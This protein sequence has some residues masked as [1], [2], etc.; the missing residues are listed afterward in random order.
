LI[1][2]SAKVG[3]VTTFYSHDARCRK[4][5]VRAGIRARD[6]PTHSEDLFIDAEMKA[7]SPL[8]AKSPAQPKPR[9]NKQ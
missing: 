7:A 4:L 3:G 5:A 8:T 1:I 6:L 2:A 9:R